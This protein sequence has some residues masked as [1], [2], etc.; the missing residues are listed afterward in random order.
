M[1]LQVLM[2]IQAEKVLD[3]LPVTFT[4]NERPVFREKIV[5]V[6]R[7]RIALRLEGAVSDEQEARLAIRIGKLMR[8]G[9]SESEAVLNAISAEFPNL[10]SI[11]DDETAKYKAELR[12]ALANESYNRASEPQSALDHTG[13]VD[14]L[15][16]RTDQAVGESI[17]L[18]GDATSNLTGKAEG[19]SEFG[20]LGV[21]LAIG[22]SNRFLTT[23]EQSWWAFGIALNWLI[24]LVISM[25]VGMLFTLIAL[26]LKRSGTIGDVPDWLVVWVPM[27]L[28]KMGLAMQL[29]IVTVAAVI[30]AFALAALE[31]AVKRRL[32][33]VDS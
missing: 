2:R 6:L 24:R 16:D 5:E 29:G 10:C 32:P 1:S 3:D 33:Y 18:V 11:L 12:D 8:D 27:W 4:A 31:A 23:A 7:Y 28:P 30:I 20:S 14:S 19:A 22:P 26:H 25:W 13:S 17:D 9:L 21:L 15:S